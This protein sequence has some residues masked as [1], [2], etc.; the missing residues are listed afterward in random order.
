MRKF[1][2]RAIVLFL[3][4]ASI[5]S[6]AQ[7][8]V[9]TIAGSGLEGNAN[10]QGANASF[11]LPY[12]VD[13]D[14][15]G[16]IFVA[17]YANHLIR[18]ITSNGTV[19][20][21]AG[22]GQNKF[23]NG[24]G[25]NAS[26]DNPF[27]LT[28]D[29]S[30]NMYVSDLSNSLIRKITPAGVVTTLAG[31][32]FQGSA[33]GTGTTA[34]FSNPQG[35]ICDA[36]GNVY[37]AD[38]GNVMIRKITP[39]GAVTNFAGS[40]DNGNGN[41]TGKDASFASPCGLAI[42]AYGNIYVADLANNLI[43]KITPSRVVSTFAGSGEQGFKDGTGNNASFNSPSGLDV[44][45]SGNIYVA[46]LGNNAIRKVTPEGVVTTLAGTGE[47]GDVDGDTSIAQFYWPSDVAIDKSG[48]LI[49]TDLKNNKIKKI[50]MNITPTGITPSAI[51]SDVKV[52][53]IPASDYF[54][55]GLT[56]K[57]GSDVRLDLINSEGLK[58]ISSTGFYESGNQ[59]L[60]LSVQSLTEG[61]YIA[62][63]YAGNQMTSQKIVIVK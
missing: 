30:G 52:Y 61:L 26:F 53:P 38:Q 62:N 28:F 51:A 31:C 23:E 44:D 12:G 19:S 18:K 47:P 11:Y 29:A 21:F 14:V 33:D 13:V 41:G 49:I 20:T 4:N 58:V 63:I 15:S 8:Q 32:G 48:N 46:D 16:N 54:T 57:N 39:S 27:D 22:S 55:V 56:I 36:S 2:R 6:N 50:N 24:I 7:L 35:I 25:T 42:D 5:L 34:C 17:D 3:C 43:R 9:T 1:L 10:G 60:T 40:G 45:A 59:E 37:E